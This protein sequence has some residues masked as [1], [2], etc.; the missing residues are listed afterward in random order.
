[1]GCGGNQKQSNQDFVEVRRIKRNDDPQSNNFNKNTFN[2]N[3]K[4]NFNDDQTNNNNKNNI[5]LSKKPQ[6]DESITKN[7]EV[8]QSKAY[9]GAESPTGSNSNSNKLKEFEKINKENQKQSG[10]KLISKKSSSQNQ[11]DNAENLSQK[12]SS[13][14][15]EN[16][17]SLSGKQFSLKDENEENDVDME[18]IPSKES[19]ESQKEKIF[20][21]SQKQIENLS[22]QQDKPLTEKQ[23]SQQYELNLIMSQQQSE[24][25]KL[26]QDSEQQKQQEQNQQL[27]S[28]TESNQHVQDIEEQKQE[29]EIVMSK[30]SEIFQD[31]DIQL[32]N[33]LAVEYV[34]KVYENGV[35]EVAQ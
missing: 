23:S 18:K 19:N 29:Q 2:N 22:I 10:I 32:R 33:A 9:A 20:N 25:Q 30:K 3:Q 12:S 1:M 5:D 17:E 13:Q 35:Q 24:Q 31:D 4:Q 15:K 21:E 7:N 6:S 26:Q 27:N 34:Q 11:I 28:K 16:A 8:D 14:Q